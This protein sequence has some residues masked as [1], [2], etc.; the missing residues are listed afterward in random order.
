MATFN[1]FNS[2][3]SE[4]HAGTHTQVCATPGTDVVR[5]A[6]TNT[7]PVATNTI[8]ANITQI[9]Y[10]NI[11]E[12]WPIDVINV[13]SQTGGIVTVTATDVTATATDTVPTFRYVVLYNDTA[14]SDELIA[15][16][17]NGSAVDLTT[18]QTF[19]VN[20]GAS[21]FTVE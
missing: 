6:L 18:G 3:V 17:D 7:P 21:L 5:A 10:T 14:A 9:A 1:K 20:F 12:T 2:F 8:L 11:S 15:W 19:T 4:L 16:Y 13:G